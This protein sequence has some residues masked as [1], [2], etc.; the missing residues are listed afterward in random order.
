MSSF[1]SSC[2]PGTF[3]II[4]CWEGREGGR[5]GGRGGWEEG[6]V[7]KR[8]VKKERDLKVGEGRE[9]GGCWEGGGMGA[10]FSG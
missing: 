2:T 7:G 3:F 8:D 10:V 4:T 5:E 1:T 9:K 6:E